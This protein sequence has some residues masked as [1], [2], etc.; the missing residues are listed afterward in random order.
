MNIYLTII[1]VIAL[2]AVVFY[3]WRKK[4][5]EKKLEQEYK[6]EVKPLEFTPRDTNPNRAEPLPPAKD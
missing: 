4:K 3:F 2:S 6:D 1:S 5:E